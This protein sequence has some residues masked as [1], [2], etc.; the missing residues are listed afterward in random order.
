[1][2][3]YRSF[4]LRALA[5]FVS[6]A[7]LLLA[8]WSVYVDPYRAQ[9]E[10]LS[11]VIDLDGTYVTKPAEG[12]AFQQWLVTTML[13]AEKFTQVTEV[14]LNEKEVNDQAL[15]RLGGLR[16]L[17]KLLL[18]YATVTDMGSAAFSGM[19]QLEVLSLQ[20]TGVGDATVG[21]L[22]RLPNL[23]HVTLTGAPVTDAAIDDFARMESLEELFLR[24]TQV[25][26]EGA[27][28]LQQASAGDVHFHARPVTAH[29][30]PAAE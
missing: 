9:A 4:S 3:G 17:R 29:P 24:W 18:N 30:F 26:P 16:Y 11:A 6:I 19:R 28:R 13:G 8:L 21:R 20:Y 15:L 5:I 22:A 12:S 23:R 10:S 2:Q 25:S 1:M 14:D 7:C 27:A